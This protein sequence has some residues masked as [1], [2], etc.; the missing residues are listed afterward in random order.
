MST[1]QTIDQAKLDEFMG[2]FVGDLGAAMSAALVV[3]GD[4][5]GLYRA[6]A[7]GEPVT[8]EELAGR[9]GTDP[10]YVREWLSNQ[11]AGAYVTYHPLGECFSL[12]PEQSLALAQEG[13]PVFVP[14]AFQLATSLIKDEP[15]ITDAFKTGHGVGCGRRLRL[16]GHVRLPAR[17]GRPRRRR[18]ARAGNA[19]F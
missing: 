4:R 17:H 3:I 9:T 6:M 8:A 14:G 1:E 11:A 15:K 10:R 7:D 13:S 18:H 2:R 12:T 16:R 19:R 5:L